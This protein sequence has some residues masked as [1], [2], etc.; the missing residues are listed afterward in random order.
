MATE[1]PTTTVA[2]PVEGN[3]ELWKLLTEQVFTNEQEWVLQEVVQIL[4]DGGITAPWQLKKAPDALLLHAFPLE[5]HARHYLVAV[6]VRDELK[7]TEA[8]KP[9]PAQEYSAGRRN[10]WTDA[11]AEDSETES[12]ALEV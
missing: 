1:V 6:H 11:G 4:K 8:P 7:A 10:Q 9:Q 3:N 5:S 2:A 12:G